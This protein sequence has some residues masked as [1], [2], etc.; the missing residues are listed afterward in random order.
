MTVSEHVPDRVSTMAA[1]PPLSR[2]SLSS[3]II[4]GL[5]EYGVV[6]VLGLLIVVMSVASPTFLSPGNL[7]N[8]LDQWAPVGIMAVAGTAVIIAGGFDL[9]TSA[10]YAL[11]GVTAAMTVN[12][13]GSVVAGFAVGI[14]TGLSIGVVNGVITTA[15]RVNPFMATLASSI[16]IRG[17]A[18]AVSAGALIS[19]SNPGFATVGLGSALGLGWSVWVF[20]T[21]V[22]VM[23]AALRWTVFGRYVYAVGGSVEA[24]R[25]SGVRV[26]VIRA[27]TFAVSGLACG[28]AG[29]LVASRGASGQAGLGLG[30]ELT[31]IAAIVIGGTSILGG[32]GAIWR[33]VVGVLLLAVIA[34]GFNLIGVEPVYQSI[35]QGLVILAAVGADAWSRRST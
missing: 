30:L 1:P 25:L 18:T 9:S 34:N 13:S 5:R 2:E 15:G 3:N 29:V 35:F 28:I 10:M 6:V 32:E 33:T 4:R 27:S 20:F 16:M 17:I 12:A 23:S 11:S 21:A 19:V 14:G 22:V 31:V 8:L 26:G 24:A 7:A